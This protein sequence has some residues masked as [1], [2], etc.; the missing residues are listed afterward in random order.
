MKSLSFFLLSLVTVAFGVSAVQEASAQG[1][2]VALELGKPIGREIGGSERHDYRVD[3]QSGQFMLVVADQ[4]GVDLA[5]TVLGPDG[6]AI[7]EFD[8]PAMGPEPAPLVAE[9]SGSYRI[10][11]RAF[12]PAAQRGR[13]AITLVRREASATTPS[14]KIDQLFAAWDR[15]GSPGAAVAVVKDG[16]IV[17]RRGFGSANLEHGVRTSPSTVFDI[18]SVSKQ[19]AGLAIAMLVDQGKVSLD[20]DIREYLPDMPDFGQRVT[21]RHLVHHTS[22][23]RDWTSVF[24]LAGT[25]F[26]DVI[27]FDQILN[28]ARHQRELNYDPGAEYSYTN[29]GYNLLA[30]IVERVTGEPFPD[31]M[32]AQVFEPLGMTSTHFHGDHDRI[33]VNRAYSYAV[34]PER[35]YRNVANNLTAL[36]SSSLYTTVEDLAKWALNYEHARVGGRAAIELTHQRGILNDGDTIGYAFGQGVGEYR[37]LRTVTHGGSWAGFRTYLLRLP[38]QRSAV[39][40]LSNLAGFPTTFMARSVADVYL[41]DQMSGSPSRLGRAPVEREEVAVD[42]GILDDYAGTY[43]LGPGWLLA[44]TREG[45]RL[46]AQATAE[47]KVAMTALSDSTFWVYDYGAA[48]VFRRDPQGEVSHIAYRG[49]RA[50]RVEPLD[51]SPEQ[52]GEYAGVYFSEELETS[53]TLV[54][55]DG[56]LVARHWRNDEVP[57]FPTAEDEFRGSVWWLRL[58]TFDRDSDGGVAGLRVTNGRVRNLRFDKRM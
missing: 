24:P 56:R 49:M 16:D 25:G 44:I 14:G 48:V 4:L 11:V 51:P 34:D 20:D 40:V 53:Y 8:G 31:W 36:G 21:V 41:A 58:L 23:L 32:E 42:A 50:P 27:T 28:M 33:V 22:G 45:D 12:D 54:V 26:E 6:E 10:T 39:I 19:F 52:L 30:E 47:D 1:G 35:G 37:G 18:A 3:L 29:T 9:A 13:Y 57:L 17:Y 55:E 43:R 15:P 7:R 5:V 38:E 2:I 46:M